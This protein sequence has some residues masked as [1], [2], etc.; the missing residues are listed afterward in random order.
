MQ[1]ERT[2]LAKRREG[3]TQKVRITP[4]SGGDALKCFI[5]VNHY[6][7][8]RPGEIFI[9]VAKQGSTMAGAFDTLAIVLSHAFQMGTPVFDLCDA[10]I[11]MRYEPIGLTD[12]PEIPD[13]S[14]L[15]DYIGRR[16]AKEYLTDDE[17]Q[18]L[19]VRMFLPT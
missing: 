12:D 13:V 11:G 15:S 17:R 10:L 2:K 16:L 18:R 8:G 3:W 9:K 7:D 5:T 6:E 14:S 19:G 4:A 1:Q